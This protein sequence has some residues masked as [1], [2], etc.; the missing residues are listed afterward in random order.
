[1]DVTGPINVFEL[2]RSLVR[3][4]GLSGE[5][6]AVGDAVG[7]AM[8]ELG[9]RSVTRD[10]LGSVVGLVGPHTA[11]PA[12]L[13]DGHMDVV[14]AIGDWTT[15]PFDPTERGGRLYGRGTT[16]M[17]GGLAAAIVGVSAAARSGRLSSTVAVSA[18][19]LEET[20][21]GI[22]LAKVL[23]ELRPGA[24]VICEPSDLAIQVG[25]RGRA[26]FVVTA[27]GQP[28]HSAYPERGRNPIGIAAAGL[29]ALAGL[30]LPM[31]HSLGR[32][33]LVATDI[34]SEPWPSISLIPASVSVRFDRRT[35]PS[36]TW[37]SVRDEVVQALASTGEEGAFTVAL[38]ADPVTACTGLRLAARRWLPAWRIDPADSLVLAAVRATRVVGHERRLGV[39]DFCTN[40]S[41]SAGV[42]GIPTI[43]LGPG[44][45]SDAHTADESVS[46]EQLYQAA[47]IYE[48]LALV[49]AGG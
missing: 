39:Y 40:G 1:V 9:F 10:P 29:A 42:R 44:V 14:P 37:D 36:E 5:E 27:A 38:S 41:E 34:I 28:A 19:V 47:K 4:P 15:D 17:K 26:E 13:F 11:A 30:V 24:V 16:D 45:A 49:I 18:T 3:I 7:S 31:D 35:L 46:V 23:D 22:A 21:E 20:V 32:A 6:T 25:Q 48:Q 2:T 33:I 12:L 43:G 8:E